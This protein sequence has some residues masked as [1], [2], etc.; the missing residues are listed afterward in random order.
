LIEDQLDEEKV[1]LCRAARAFGAES[2]LPRI[3]EA[4]RD[5]RF[6]REI[7]ASLARAAISVRRSTA[8]AALPGTMSLTG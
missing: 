1:T 5:E 2:L 3:V 6:D 4:A 7:V 8:V